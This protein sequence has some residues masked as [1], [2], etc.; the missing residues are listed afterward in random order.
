MLEWLILPRHNFDTTL[1]IGQFDSPWN[2]ALSTP[3]VRL[4]DREICLDKTPTKLYFHLSRFVKFQNVRFHE[5]FGRFLESIFFD[6]RL[7]NMFQKAF[8]CWIVEYPRMK[9]LSAVFFF[10]RNM[11]P[12]STAVPEKMFLWNI[13]LAK[14][15]A[16]KAWLQRLSCLENGVCWGTIST[17]SLLGTTP[18]IRST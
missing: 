7:I 10:L 4:F 13:A 18:P 12:V 5:A 14:W 15:R 6:I 11:P 16:G 1:E 2:F 9:T 8:F 3:L 17:P